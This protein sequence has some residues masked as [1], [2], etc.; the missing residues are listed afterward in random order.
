MSAA[1]RWQYAARILFLPLLVVYGCSGDE[2][3]GAR[4][5]GDATEEGTAPVVLIGH[6]QLVD[7][8]DGITLAGNIEPYEQTTIYAR[9][10][11]YIDKLHVDIGDKVRAGD[12]LAELTVPEMQYE[13][14]VVISVVRQFLS[15]VQAIDRMWAIPAIAAVKKLSEN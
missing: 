12:V 2:P 4:T 1:R 15:A 6:P 7:V 8:E 9:V 13:I 11:G 10:T 3:H 5:T 14:W